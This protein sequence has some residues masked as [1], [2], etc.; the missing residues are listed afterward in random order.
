VLIEHA[1]D[2][3]KLSKTIMENW[4]I[5]HV[6]NESTTTSIAG[7]LRPPLKEGIRLI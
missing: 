4:R 3:E 1:G 2:Y 5:Y 7:G 6:E